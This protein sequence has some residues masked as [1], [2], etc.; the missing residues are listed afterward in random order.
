MKKNNKRLD[1]GRDPAHDSYPGILKKGFLPLLDRGGGTVRILSI[2]PIV[3]D[4][5]LCNF[6]RG[7]KSH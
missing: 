7:G 4:A 1:F 2:S 6:Q 5:L 3:V